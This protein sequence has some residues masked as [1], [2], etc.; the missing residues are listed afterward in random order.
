[1]RYFLPKLVS[2]FFYVITLTPGERGC[3]A[4]PSQVAV[5][6]AGNVLV[7]EKDALA[8]SERVVEDWAVPPSLRG[9]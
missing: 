8:K 5:E 1:M 4:T 2:I 3:D 6:R 7:L 9:K